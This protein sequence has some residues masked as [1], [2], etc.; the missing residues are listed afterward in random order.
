MAKKNDSVFQVSLTEIAFTLLILIAILLGTLLALSYDEN[1]KLESLLTRQTN[2][3]S[4]HRVHAPNPSDPTLQEIKPDPNAP[5]EKQVSYKQILAS[6]TGQS[7]DDSIK[8]VALG[9]DAFSKWKKGS[10]V[11]FKDFQDELLKCASAIAAGDPVLT[12]EELEKSG[13]LGEKL[14]EQ[15]KEISKLRESNNYYRVRAGLDK[16]P[17]WLKDNQPEYMFSVTLQRDNTVQVL[18]IWPEDRDAEA[19]AVP[20]VIDMVEKKNMSVGEFRRLAAPILRDSD[21]QKPDACRYYVQLRNL[22]PDRKTADI[23]RLIVEQYFYKLEL[24]K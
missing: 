6:V 9:N 14:A 19:R 20:G 2:Y 23:S 18:P 7:E 10:H 3:L 4:T 22:V 11:A 17:C 8:V 16:P 21:N 24:V 1:S 15:Q 5:I 12:K 13:G